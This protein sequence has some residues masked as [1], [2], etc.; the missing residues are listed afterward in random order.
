MK[1]KQIGSNQAEL[2]L[3]NK[4]VLFSY[5]TPVAVRFEDS[6]LEYRTDE[7]FSQTTEKHIKA[8]TNTHRTVTQY[9]IEWVLEGVAKKC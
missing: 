3:G 5:E 9:Q 4:V 7:K 8:W 2:H 6:G 1:L